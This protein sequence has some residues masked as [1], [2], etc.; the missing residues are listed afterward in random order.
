MWKIAIFVPTLYF[1]AAVLAGFLLNSELGLIVFLKQVPLVIPL[2]L[3]G[4][5]F[6][7]FMGSFAL[8]M[9]LINRIGFP[10]LLF[11]PIFLC[12]VTWIHLSLLENSKASDLRLAILAL[13]ANNAGA[14]LP[15]WLKIRGFTDQARTVILIR[16]VLIIGPF[17]MGTIIISTLSGIKRKKNRLIFSLSMLIG[18]FTFYSYLAAGYALGGAIQ[19]L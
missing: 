1:L 2:V 7:L 13:A 8:D 19:R 9:L 18:S 3:N 17:C 5:S 10:Y 16:S 6:L 11:W 14:H 12:V 4:L 15:S